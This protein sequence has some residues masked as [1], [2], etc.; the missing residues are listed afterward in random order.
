MIPGASIPNANH[1]VRRAAT[2]TPVVLALGS[3]RCHG[4]HGRP[5][6]IVR[7]AVAELAARGLAD[8]RLSPIIHTSPLGPSTRRFANA[9]VAGTWFG[10]AEHLLATAKALEHGFGRRP[11][12]RWGARVLDIDIIAFGR[13]RIIAPGLVIPHPRMAERAFVLAPMRAIAPEWRHPVTGRTV[14]HMAAR[15]ERRHPCG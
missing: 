15:L 6:A 9:A 2:A 4:R 1:G 11:G 3:N 7:A 10:T 8:V 14:R 12:R 13:Q 5:A